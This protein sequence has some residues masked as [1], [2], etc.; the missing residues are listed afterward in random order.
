M[1]WEEVSITSLRLDFVKLAT[2]EGANMSELCRC[3][4]I[5]RKTGYKWLERYGH[6]GKE[7]LVDQSRRPHTSPNRTPAEMEETVLQIRCKYPAWG[8]R[9]IRWLLLQ[10]GYVDVPSPSTITAILRRHGHIDPE[11][12]LKHRAFQRFQ[13]EYPNELWQMDFKGYF[14]LTEGGYCHPLTVLDDCS[15]FLVGLRACPDETHET[16]QD[17]LTSIF[18]CY[19]MPDRMLMD[20]GSPWGD[21]ADNPYTRLTAWLIRLGI[22]VSHGRPYHPQTQGKD[23]RL[24][25]T[26][27]AELISRHSFPDLPA[28]QVLFDDWRQTYNLVRPHEALDMAVPAESYQPSSRPFPDTLPPVLYD[29]SDTVRKVDKGG[30][31]S[32]RNHTFRVGKA[33]RY[34]PVAIRPTDTDGDFDVFFCQQRVAHIS[35][36]IHDA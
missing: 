26:L 22:G 2:Q 32:F 10:D 19:G 30:R 4:G 8:G 36:H 12:S 16:V 7:S 18:R 15:R 24:H 9:K 35:L 33:F 13:K 27:N 17:Q 14:A 1:P 5:S 6:G 25:R 23:E 31:I 3:F 11:E 21:D 34:Q 28:C 29:A 20:N